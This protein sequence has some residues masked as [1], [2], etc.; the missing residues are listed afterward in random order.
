MTDTPH[1]VLLMTPFA[2]FD[3][4]L[5]EGIARYNQVHGPWVFYRA[6]DYPEVPLPATESLSGGFTGP[7]YVSAG[8]ASHPFPNLRSWGATG[9][10]GRIL[11]AQI[12]RKI[13]ASGL[14]AIG[15][16][17]PESRSTRKGPLAKI[18]EIWTDSHQAGRLAA[19]HFLERGFRQFAF[20]GYLGRNWSERRQEGFSQRLGEA[21]FACDVYQP[22]PR[23]RRLSWQWEQRLVLSWLQSLPKPVGIMSCNDDRG[24]QV[25]EAS[26]LAGIRVPDDAAVV[27]ADNH[28][29]ICNLSNPP[30]SSV[31]F[32]LEQAGYQAAELLEGL[33]SGRIHQPRRIPVQALWV[34]P[35]RSTEVIATD[36]RHVGVALRFIRD[37]A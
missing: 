34:V 12:A 20:C 22:G 36:D 8:A 27:G 14:P 18:S 17:L 6:S 4:G 19:E 30:L 7:E 28:H 13:L 25:L 21:G 3:Q 16:D 9:V 2:G 26:L 23:K 32:N 24:R 37:R 29:L 5:A 1:V 35:R 10:I 33:M 31:A 11:T 15:I